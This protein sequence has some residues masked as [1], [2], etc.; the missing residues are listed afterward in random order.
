MIYAFTF[1]LLSNPPTFAF[2]EPFRVK[3]AGTYIT[4][5]QGHAAPWMYDWDKDGVDDLLV[6]QFGSGK[7]RI[8]HNHGTNEKPEFRDFKWFEAGGALAHVPCG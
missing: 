8:Y 6:G 7:L 1:G 4:V 2:Q 3:A 5:D